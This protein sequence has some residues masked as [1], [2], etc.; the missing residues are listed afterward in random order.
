M[1]AAFVFD[2]ALC[3]LIVAV[4]VTA[5]AARSHFAAIV[6][7]IV[8]GL[9]V[10][11]AWVRL[12]AIDVALTE[13]AIGAG[14]TGLLLVGAAARFGPDEA[15]RIAPTQTVRRLLGKLGQIAICATGAAALVV[16]LRMLPETAAG[17]HPLVQQKLAE[18]GVSNP[19]TAVLLNFR[20]YDTLLESI[21]LTISLVGIWSLAPDRLWAGV[22]GAAHH[23]RPEGVLAH[24][25]RALPSVG[26]LVGVHLLWA[27]ADAP[28]G[29]FQAG[30]VLA[31]VWLLA[32]MAGLTEAP[33]VSSLRLRALI[34]LGPAFFLSIASIGAFAGAFLGYSTDIAKMSIFAIEALL[35]VSIAVT[36]ALAILG[37]PRRTR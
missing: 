16:L 18:S 15:A 8:Y 37:A 5:V 23:A 24:F 2:L 6:F 9:F 35:T 10:A 3:A 12:E 7:F 19:V 1:T 28:G 33:A 25:A 13:A 14:L 11:I 4:A 21:V 36:L 20:A 32:V 22:P 31:A 29:A 26:L 27:G 17:L 30:T 34:V